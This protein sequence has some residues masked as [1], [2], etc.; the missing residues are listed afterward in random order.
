MPEISQKTPPVSHAETP[1]S[2]ETG[3]GSRIRRVLQ[4]LFGSNQP[5]RDGHR[6]YGRMLLGLRRG[7]SHSHE[8]CLQR[9]KG[10]KIELER[11]GISYSERLGVLRQLV[12][13]YRITGQEQA[14]RQTEERIQT[15][16]DELYK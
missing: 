6:A 13:F 11:P 10:L 14:A 4:K 5:E 15:L 3:V 1:R 8:L 2:E 7:N 16:E 9:I 12:E